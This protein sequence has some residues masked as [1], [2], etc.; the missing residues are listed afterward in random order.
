MN[1]KIG[2]V[3]QVDRLIEKGFTPS[4]ANPKRRLRC[5]D[6]KLGYIFSTSCH[7]TLEAISYHSHES[8]C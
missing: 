4:V 5:S 6:M 8:S 1:S 2:H 3:D 7:W